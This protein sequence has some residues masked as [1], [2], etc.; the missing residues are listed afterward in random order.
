MIFGLDRMGM[1][2]LSCVLLPFVTT[3]AMCL[4]KEY[5]IDAAPN[6][7]DL[8]SGIGGAGLAVVSYTIDLEKP[9]RGK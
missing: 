2:K 8:F 9:F 1:N 4:L 6:T 5:V 7:G 3:S